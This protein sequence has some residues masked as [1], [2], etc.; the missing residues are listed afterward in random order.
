[1][2]IQTSIYPNITPQRLQIALE[3]LTAWEELEEGGILEVVKTKKRPEV[4]LIR[5][6]SRRF[7]IKLVNQQ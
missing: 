2:E 1:M 5:K 6:Q 4:P 7:F 3:L